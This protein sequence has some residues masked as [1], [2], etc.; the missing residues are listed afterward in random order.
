MKYYNIIR[1]GRVYVYG[2][3]EKRFIILV[4]YFGFF[5]LR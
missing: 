3:K 4:L 1:M 2:D 5:F